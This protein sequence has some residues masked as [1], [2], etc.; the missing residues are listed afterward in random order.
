MIPN[1]G[2]TL[3]WTIP[4]LIKSSR[5]ITSPKPG[6]GVLPLGVGVSLFVVLLDAL[7]VVG[8]AAGDGAVELLVAF[9][10]TFGCSVVVSVVV[11]TGP[12][13]VTGATWGTGAGV[14]GTIAV[15]L[16]GFRGLTGD[17]GLVAFVIDFTQLL[18][19]V[20]QGCHTG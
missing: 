1:S 2:N 20:T 7:A 12:I 13:A 11:G 9:A 10:S 19:V 5:L 6:T 18:D 14:E 8:G 16:D 15:G 3:G 4:G 17:T